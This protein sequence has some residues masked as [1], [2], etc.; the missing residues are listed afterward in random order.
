MN[1]F[2]ARS[3]LARL[4]SDR[5]RKIQ[6]LLFVKQS[7]W[8]VKANELFLQQCIESVEEFIED[9][10][11]ERQHG[12]EQKVS[13]NFLAQPGELPIISPQSGTTAAT[14]RDD[15]ENSVTKNQMATTRSSRCTSGENEEGDEASMA[16][17]KNA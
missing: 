3:N 10:F 4:D 12:H 7:N 17:E 5:L 15:L 2:Y 13:S 1:S 11:N 9:T 14:H 16:K 8:Q 6:A